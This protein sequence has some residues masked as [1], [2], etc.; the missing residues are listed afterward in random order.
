MKGTKKL[1]D[2]TVKDLREYFKI[3]DLEIE[4]VIDE[5]YKCIWQVKWQDPDDRLNLDDGYSYSEFGISLA[6]EFTL[7]EFKWLIDK[8]INLEFSI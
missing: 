2:L 1:S 3:P 7:Y 5:D 6:G 4:K 8:G